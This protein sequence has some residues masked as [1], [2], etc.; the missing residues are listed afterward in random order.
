MAW[1]RIQLLLL[2]AGDSNWVKGFLSV[3]ILHKPGSTFLYNSLGTYMLSAI[4]QK[5]TGQK[6]IDYLKPRL[7]DPLGITV[8]IG[9]WTQKASTPVA[10]GLRIRTEDMAKFGQLFLQKGMWNG[11]QIYLL[12]GWKKPPQ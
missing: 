12:H 10:W 2:P 11:K 1:N 5:V 7:F 3:P 4:V 8:W 9:K 6:V